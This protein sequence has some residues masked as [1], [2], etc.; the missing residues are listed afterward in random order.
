MSIE[1]RFKLLFYHHLLT[2]TTDSYFVSA[3][4]D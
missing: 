1:F 3:N 2:K 4:N